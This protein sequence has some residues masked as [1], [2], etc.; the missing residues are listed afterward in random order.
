MSAPLLLLSASVLLCFTG[1]RVDRRSG[2]HDTDATTFLA[3]RAE[4]QPMCLYTFD[5]STGAT[6]KNRAPYDSCP[7][8]ALQPDT[9][10]VT[11]L[12][13]AST[14]W[15]LGVHVAEDPSND[16][17]RVQLASVSSVSARDF[18]TT[19][20]VRN[21]TVSGAGVTFELVIRRRAATNRSMTL[22]SVANQYDDCADSGFRLDLN[23]H[24][25]LAF[26]YF[27]PVLEEGGEAGVEAC[28]EQRLFSV[29][30]SAAC[31]LPPVLEPAE[32]TP[33]VQITVTLDPSSERGRWTTDFY[34][35][36]T[37]VNT[38]Q[39][40]DCQV[41]DEQ[42]PPTAQV[43][44]K[45]IQGRYRLYVGNS[46]R[47]VTAP[48]QRKRLAAARTSPS[49]G[50]T[51][52]LNATER[53][54]V[55]LKQKLTSLTGPRLPQ[56]MRIFG[57]N[58]L[59]L[60]VL[61]ITFPP[62]NEDTPLA[63]LRSKLADFKAQYGD[64]IVDYLVNLVQQKARTHVV[65]QRAQASSREDSGASGTFSRAALFQGAGSATFDL[66]H[67]A[68]YRRVVSKEQVNALSRQQLLP[69]RQF[70]ALQQT[71][72][73]PE[74]SL[75]LLNLTM[76]HGVFDDLR[77]ELR[78]LP[79]FGQL[80]LLP[81]KT[82]VTLANK[83][84]FRDLPLEHQRSIFFR[85]EPDQ[86][87]DNLPL[88]NAVAFSRRL[89][90]YA[91]VTFGIAE[92]L[93]GRSVNMSVEAKIDIFVD[94][95]NG[96]PR[97][98][99][100]E[101]HVRV[102]KGVPVTLDL[103][104][105]DV[106]GAPAV[107]ASDA[108]GGESSEFLASF[109]FTDASP[110][111]ASA[112]QF[113]KVVR[114]PRFGKLFDC[115]ASC[116]AWSFADDLGVG[117]L[118]ST[119]VP[120]NSSE[121]ANAT[122]S[123]NLIYMYDGQGQADG[124]GNGSTSP[125]ADELWYVLSDG[126]PGVFSNVAVVKFVPERGRY[127][128]GSEDAVVIVRL[129]EDSLQLVNLGALTASG[130]VST[131][132]QLTALPR[133]GS[134]FQYDPQDGDD[135][136]AGDESLATTAANTSLGARITV[137]DTIVSDR[138]G[139]VL[140]APERNYYNVEPQPSFERAGEVDYFE[141]QL[142]D[143]SAPASDSLAVQ[144][145]TARFADGLTLRRVQ[146]EVVNAPDA[147]VILPPFTFT[148]NASNRDA[149][150]TPVAFD[151]PDGA[152]PATV[153]QV[154]LEAADGISELKL[155]FAITDDDVMSGCSFGRPCTLLRST[156]GAPLDGSS[157]SST[158]GELRFHIT[159][160]L[161][162]P[163]HVQVMGSKAALSS[164]LSA[165][166][167]RDLS[168]T[169][170][171]EAHTAEFVLWLERANE[172][173]GDVLQAKRTFTISFPAGDGDGV[174]S[175]DHVLSAL[176]S[177][178]RRYVSTL[179]V[180]AAAWLVLANASCLSLGFC[181]CCCS[182]TRKKR[183]RELQERQRRFRAQ[184]A[185][186]DHEYSVL[187]M[188]LA[189]LILE[190]TLLVSRC[191]LGSCVA[192][193]ASPKQTEV[194]KEAFILRSLLPVLESERQG[195]RFVFQLM[196]AEYQERTAISGSSFDQQEFLIRHSTASKALACFCR[197]IGAKW[198]SSL[199]LTAETSSIYGP[200]DMTAELESLMD[201]LG[202]QA[203][204]LPAEIVILCRAC[205]KL[206]HRGEFDQTREL[207]LAAVHLVFFDHF[208]GPALLF[209]RECVSGFAPSAEQRRI[210][211]EMAFRIA[212]LSDQWRS[213]DQS[214]V[215][216]VRSRSSSTDRLLGAFSAET[217]GTTSC[218]CQYEAL[219]ETIAR[220]STIKS[221]YDPNEA[222]ADVDCELMG[223]CLMNVH[224]LLNGSFPQFQRRLRQTQTST[225]T[226]QT[227]DAISR[228]TRLLKALGW[229]LASIHQLVEYA[230]PELA[231][232]PLLWNGWSFR[233]WQDRAQAQ[234]HHQPTSSDHIGSEIACSLLAEQ[235]NDVELIL[236]HGT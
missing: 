189:N 233:D 39:R 71:V 218:R 45:L 53:L 100:S 215:D 96:A 59:S 219:L 33:P 27:L 10:L 31:Q 230:R 195:T 229:P 112:S 173:D 19:A 118:A 141:Y 163:S 4:W 194:L 209:P 41:H 50:N 54:R 23:E 32:R 174:V 198:L 15:Q 3:E 13:T 128:S 210:L 30:T 114:L 140:Y 73:I 212:R 94:A 122:H 137:P 116:G 77:L 103:G 166:T 142:L 131:R 109:T 205:A 62:L 182:K 207:E 47:G 200:E 234:R 14:F 42:H 180:L 125:P 159:P 132:F 69:S 7:F 203:E 2:D 139:R 56:A 143:T 235:A 201:R 145:S 157:N 134:L 186:D 52:S 224:S 1:G 213:G 75:A 223:L 93:A 117:S 154:N 92:S 160:Q 20:V 108:G 179:L 60:H 176:K 204:E 11:S 127:D 49:L 135:A 124:S 79:E 161:Y 25:V 85:P 220:S 99:T 133:H 106:D 16:S 101:L 167:F 34:V 172:S 12:N 183:R 87:N 126:D 130:S 81:N 214:K 65:A 36:Y 184:V 158:G 236:E 227:E 188:S 46:P 177:Q 97:P 199:L 231:A 202:K 113:L 9:E 153:Y 74:N 175:G 146:F 55:M 197:A 40:V 136:S 72:R 98:R 24:Q 196:A 152:T 8:D 107:T 121:L 89:E 217:H 150:P 67:L 222:I 119:R 206:F 38:M 91:T 22:F 115:S 37:D 51:S 232:D 120:P 104:G 165:L 63:Y 156:S 162:D 35:S 48:R 83:A 144:S 138:R 64:Q 178:L 164:A 185:Q 21:A 148:T 187:L 105:D 61:G 155:G 168:G 226:E 5:D 28:Y 90:P 149:I 76:L 221:S 44:H 84:L 191:L 58:S 151:D 102:E 181:C 190:P 192:S 129:G 123:T 66:F 80:L 18:F 95:V 17:R 88:P 78:G 193:T 216:D 110:V 169:I 170:T 147:L 225:T 26:V 111:A 208:L 57:D 86:N 171:D 211:R 43:L 6:V 68:I 29:D 228:T 70:P 82:A